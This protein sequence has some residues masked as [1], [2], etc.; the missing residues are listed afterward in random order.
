[1]ASK[2]TKVL[3][4]VLVVAGLSAVG[5]WFASV[6]IESPADAAARAAPPKPS[7]ILVPVEQRVLSSS[8]VTRGTARFGLPQPVSIAP[9]ALKPDAGA[10][11]TLPRRNEQFNDGDV[12]L[13]ASGRPIFVLQ[14]NVPVY[15][16]LFPT[17]YGTDVMQLEEGLARFGFDPGPVDGV[18]SQETSTAVAEWYEASGWE[19]FAPTRDQV[20]SLRA[21]E[22]DLADARKSLLTAGAVSERSALTVNAARAAANQSGSSAAAEIRAREAEIQQVETP[23]RENP[24]ATVELARATAEH[25]NRV[26]AADVATAIVDRAVIVLDPRQPESARRA[27]EAKL[28]L[29][30]AAAERIRLEGEAAV[31][32]AEREATMRNAQLEATKAALAAARAT[33]RSAQVEGKRAIQVARD[34][35]KVAESDLELAAKWVDQLEADVASARRKLGVQV[36]AD[37]IVFL[38]SLP[39]RVEEVTAIIGDAARGRIMSVTDNQLAIDSSLPLDAAPLV[40]PGMRVFIDERALGIK[41]E[42]TVQM[43]ASSPGTRGVDGYH[44]YFEV[45]VDE[46][47]GNIEGF[48]LRLTIPIESTN[49]AV[50]VVPLSALSMLADGTSRI[51]VAGDDGILEYIAVEPGLS[52]EGFVEVEPV[53]GTLKPGRLVVVGYEEP[54]TES[55]Q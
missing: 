21:L 31:R 50:T 45:R 2:Q 30:R 28:E 13:S 53:T 24:L 41:A 54:T 27:A 43:V 34:D 51:Q 40:K 4:A 55:F 17:L 25:N 19:P 48:S 39:V 16:D 36:P 12:L 9:S 42:G 46:A 37:E 10:I 33:Y 35:Q 6:R 15:R 8:I 26:A 11:A 22:R 20:A 1:M 49:D 5:A 38:P 47:E 44:I 14:G 23:N 3:L 29:A 52:A 7:P 32:A 18:Y